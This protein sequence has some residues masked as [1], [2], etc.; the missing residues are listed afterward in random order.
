MNR[1]QDVPYTFNVIVV[2]R[3][4]RVIHIRPVAMPSVRSRHC[5][6]YSNDA[7]FT[8]VY[9]LFHTVFFDLPP[10]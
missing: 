5:C 8:F 2:Q 1:S 3:D 6:S 4:I 7:R 9:E 10:L